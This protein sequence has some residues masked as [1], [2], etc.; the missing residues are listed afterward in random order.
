[1]LPVKPV[2]VRGGHR[3][4]G[5]LSDQSLDLPGNWDGLNEARSD[6]MLV[7]VGTSFVQKDMLGIAEEVHSMTGGRCRVVSCQCG[8]CVEK[9]H[10]PHAVVEFAKNGKTY[11]V[12]GFREFGRHVI[13]RMREI[14]VSNNPNK[15]AMKKNA[16]LYAS[17]KKRAQEVQQEKLEVIE[18]ALRS[19]KFDWR[20]PSG[21][22]TDPLRTRL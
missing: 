2:T 7:P 11:P 21:M 12:F 6:K 20:G 22:R 9:G 4:S 18:A 13:D 19:P 15:K 5:A 17:R 14:H 10:F 8:Q 1:M 3:G 16:E